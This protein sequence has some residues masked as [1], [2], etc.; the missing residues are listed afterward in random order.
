MAKDD[1]CA[2]P[3]PYHTEEGHIAPRDRIME[4]ME[5]N[6]EAALHREAT[7]RDLEGAGV[8]FPE[9]IRRRRAA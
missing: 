6:A 2:G 5:R 9:F 4:R 8:P 1:L 7:R 3:M